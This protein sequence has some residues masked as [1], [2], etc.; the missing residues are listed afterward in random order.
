MCGFTLVELLV[1]ITILAV[2]A[3]LGWR[4]LDGIVRARVALTQ[5]LEKMRGMQLTFAQLQNDCARASDGA[6]LRDAVP[7][8]V[9]GQ[10]LILVRNVYAD[11]QPS[12]MQVV[13]YRLHNGALTRRES[14]A[15]RDLAEL[16]RLWKIAHD[17]ADATQEVTLQANAGTMTLRFWGNNGWRESIADIAPGVDG[18]AVNVRGIEVSLQPGGAGTIR[19]VFLLGA[20]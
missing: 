4:G 5:N 10:R 1:A 19:K 6:R 12:R 9:E 20:A 17:D 3:V 13:T 8:A 15:T 7:L 18:S 2:V 11:D 14:L 16:A